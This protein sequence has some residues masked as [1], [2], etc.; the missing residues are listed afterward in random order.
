MDICADDY[1]RARSV[2]VMIPLGRGLRNTIRR[3]HGYTPAAYTMPTLGTHL[4]LALWPE[5][6]NGG[7]DA[8]PGVPQDV[9]YQA[10][11]AT[12]AEP[13]PETGEEDTF[14][15]HSQYDHGSGNVI[16]ALGPGDMIITAVS[17]GGTINIRN[18]GEAMHLPLTQHA[19]AVIRHPAQANLQAARHNIDAFVQVEMES[20]TGTVW[21]HQRRRHVVTRHRDPTTSS[22]SAEQNA[23]AT[24]G[25]FGQRRPNEEANPRT[26]YTASTSTL[27]GSLQH[28]CHVQWESVL[29]APV[30]DNNP[31]VAN[32]A[33]EAAG[34]VLSS[35][36][37][38]ASAEM[39]QALATWLASHVRNR[40]E[41]RAPNHWC[42]SITTVCW[43]ISRA[44]RHNGNQQGLNVRFLASHFGMNAAGMRQ[45]PIATWEQG[46]TT[47]AT[48]LIRARCHQARRA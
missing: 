11:R 14:Q 4:A 6:A 3:D 33:R 27:G 26:P 1:E 48:R 19:W 28:M 25:R 29:N 47:C 2:A 38:G 39:T 34:E 13:T 35:F 24:D 12:Q 10:R 37:T 40:R 32:I 7:R 42:W 45:R 30:V 31:L 36:G 16:I 43:P 9:A 46:G 18:A 17:I 5:S 15:I 20:V 22:E 23:P 21:H 41:T 44:M 8:S